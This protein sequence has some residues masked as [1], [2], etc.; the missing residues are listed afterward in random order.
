MITKTL[1]VYNRDEVY[2]YKE[3]ADIVG[4]RYDV[5]ANASRLGIL[6]STRIAGNGSLKFILKSE[7]DA[8]VGMKEVTSK[9]AQAKINEVRRTAE[10]ERKHRAIDELVESHPD[11]VYVQ[12][13][14]S[15]GEQ[16]TM[17]PALASSQK[18]N[19]LKIILQRYA[20]GIDR[21]GRL[22]DSYLSADLTKP[23]GR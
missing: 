12:S 22:I 11:N 21:L 2:T 4:V 18:G 17:T 16:F 19:D 15:Y 20:D 1:S 9:A 6:T 8:V 10:L 13:E 23:R 3:A 7:V 5:I 14:M